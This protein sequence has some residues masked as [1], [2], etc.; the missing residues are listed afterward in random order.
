[1][2]KWLASLETDKIKEYVFATGRLKEIR[3]ASALLDDLNRQMTPDQAPKAG[4]EVVFMGGGSA[5][6]VFDQQSAAL[7]FCERVAAL[8]L[9]TTGSCSI[10][11]TVQSYDPDVKERDRPDSFHS[12][13]QAA[14]SHLQSAKFASGRIPSALLS[15]PLWVRCERCGIYP[16]TARDRDPGTGWV[17]VCQVCKTK[18]ENSQPA[19][20]DLKDNSPAARFKRQAQDF[21]AGLVFPNELGELGDYIGLVYADGNGIGNFIRDHIDTPEEMRAFSS[22]LEQAIQQ[23]LEDATR[24]FWKSNL[25]GKTVP[26]LPII[27]G[28]D[29]V[30]LI[31]TGRIAMRVASQLCLKFQEHMLALSESILLK[32]PRLF[33]GQ[34]I[35]VGMSA[36]VMIAKSSYPLFALEPLAAELLRSAKKLTNQLKPDHGIQPA[37]DFRVV[38]STS[39]SSLAAIQN[40]EYSIRK[41]IQATCRPYPCNRLARLARPAWGD[42][43]EAVDLLR[44][45]H[46]P[47][48]KLHAWQELLHAS[49]DLQAELDLSVI[50][51][52]LSRA[53]KEL[54][55]D[56]TTR[57][58][59]FNNALDLFIENIPERGQKSSPLADIEEIYEFCVS[60]GGA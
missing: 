59:H 48:N 24:P 40:Y 12:A 28:G 19:A 25:D 36:G 5:M 37:I 17:Q 49:S 51:S 57:L 16:A 6:L 23:S 27:L 13:M 15:Q 20:H 11:T 18:R 44:G 45:A 8:Y 2:L 56:I 55:G 32:N 7:Q 54:M 30:L 60:G 42:I 58:L 31:T 41:G 43:E 14:G 35:Q 29:D 47:R 1:M 33:H 26:F 34:P 52:H 10:T 4:V 38:S 53:E 39:A 3:G 22:M 46:F 21:P 9:E 50:R